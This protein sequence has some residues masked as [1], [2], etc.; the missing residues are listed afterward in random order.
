[1]NVL[2]APLPDKSSQGVDGGQ[3]LVASGHTALS[4]FFQLPEEE[5]DQIR[6]DILNL[7]S[8]NRFPGMFGGKRQ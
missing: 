2:R 7:E 4:F 6:G 5:A 1:M 3:A 8:I